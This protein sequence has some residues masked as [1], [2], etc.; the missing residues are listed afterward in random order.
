MSTRITIQID[1]R[2]CHACPGW[3]VLQAAR[4]N[5]VYIPSLCDDPLCGGSRTCR[6]CLVAVDGDDCPVPAC[7]L[8]AREGMNVR[9]DSPRVRAT[10]RANL[11]RIVEKLSPDA[12]RQI[13][14][15]TALGR[16]MRFLGLEGGGLGDR[17][18]GGSVR[19]PVDDLHPYIGFRP[20][21]CIA[22]G[23]CVRRCGEIQV[24]AAMV[25]QDCPPH[26]PVVGQR[27]WIDSP[28][29]SCG[30]CVEGCPT[31][32]ISDIYSA[33]SGLVREVVTTCGHCGAGCQVRLGIDSGAGGI[34]GATAAATEGQPP[35]L[36]VRGKY[37]Y[38]F[39]TS[40]DRVKTPRRRR[41]GRFLATSWPDAL[42][43]AADRLGEIRD[44]HGP[45][46]VAGMIGHDLTCQAM[47][48]FKAFFTDVLDGSPLAAVPDLVMPPLDYT[49]DNALADAADDRGVIVVMGCEPTAENPVIGSRIKQAVLAG[50]K[51][52][53][54]APAE[55]EL[56]AMATVHVT[57]EPTKE[58]AVL[59]FL[60]GRIRENASEVVPDRLLEQCTAR[61]ACRACGASDDLLER[62]ADLIDRSAS[63][64]LVVGADL[65][66]ARF[67]SVAAALIERLAS[68]A[69]RSWKI[70]Y[71]QEHA[72]TAGL[73]RVFGQQ[74]LSPAK[75]ILDGLL[76]GRIRALYLAGAD[77]VRHLPGG[78]EVCRALERADVIIIHE[79]FVTQTAR[80]ADLILP[81]SCWVEHTGT[82]LS[83]SGQGRDV[84]AA[85]DAPD[86][87]RDDAQVFAALARAMGRR[88]QPPPLLPPAKPLPRCQQ[89]LAEALA[90]GHW[91]ER[92]LEP[93]CLRTQRFPF[94]L[95]LTRH[96]P[97]HGNSV[98]TGRTGSLRLQNYDPLLINRTDA[99]RM[100]V[101]DGETVEVRSLVAAVRVKA[102]HSERPPPGT[103]M[104]SNQF[105]PTASN[106]LWPAD[107]AL[108]NPIAVNV[109]PCPAY[110]LHPATADQ[111]QFKKVRR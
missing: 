71:L 110:L 5:A 60:A 36:C 32:A 51:L 75:H 20:D 41:N 77:P 50:A 21:L 45:Q 66:A 100:D 8:P 17:K 98:F 101:M 53:T 12:V 15:D 39:T 19:L 74:R 57:I 84:H 70:I 93:A 108:Q 104:L 61:W 92:L 85:L 4:A 103:L 38:R 95:V 59:A 43:W 111:E 72:N 10:A 35:Q 54:V 56:S 94:T 31:G 82:F 6:L 1:G 55:N 2:A 96:W 87:V 29:V 86:G 105:S 25:K 3:T 65:F 34:V 46:A 14:R 90:D 102:I 30:L 76:E 109:R 83:P 28:C 73:A 9:T 107:S 13:H 7:E 37:A 26:G 48:A 42:Q 52:V 80:F 79:L 99:E 91:R 33:W 63:K 11:Q 27:R 40:R 89:T 64:L 69:S 97:H 18:D 62:A 106:I 88:F 24:D 81:A 67:G 58:P 23:R 22:C 16:A 47:L 68:R 49:S 78:L 44:K